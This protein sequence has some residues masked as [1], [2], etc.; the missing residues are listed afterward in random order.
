MHVVQLCAY[1]CLYVL[2]RVLICVQLC[3]YC[4][5][6]SCTNIDQVPVLLPHSK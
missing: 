4:G 2:V 1:M 3:E 6:A 5:V